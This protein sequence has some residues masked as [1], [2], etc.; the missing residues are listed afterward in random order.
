M[1][2]HSCI[3]K[4]AVSRKLRDLPFFIFRALMLV[5]SLNK[6]DLESNQRWEEEAGPKSFGI[7][8]DLVCIGGSGVRHVKSTRQRCYHVYACKCEY[9]ASVHAHVSTG[10]AKKD[11][12]QQTCMSCI[13][14]ALPTATTGT[15]DSCRDPHTC[16]QMPK[17]HWHLSH[18]LV[19]SWCRQERWLW[20]PAEF[21]DH[22][23]LSPAHFDDENKV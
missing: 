15:A 18:R 6:N 14:Y 20:L 19:K 21:T 10:N 5:P 11:V 7:L 8:Q 3:F 23:L 13:M 17:M 9:S 2:K 22:G 16:S 12:P 1:N 4:Y